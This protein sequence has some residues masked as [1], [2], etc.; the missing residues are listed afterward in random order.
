MKYKKKI[1]C[2]LLLLISLTPSLFAESIM[3]EPSGVDLS[4]YYV[5]EA[6]SNNPNSF[7]N[8]TL[9]TNHSG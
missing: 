2:L 1:Y 8:S 6:D 5:D 7:N 3:Y 4:N 9:Y